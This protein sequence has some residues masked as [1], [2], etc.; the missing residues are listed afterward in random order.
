MLRNKTIYYLGLNDCEQLKQI[1][2]TDVAINRIKA[3]F[4]DCNIT[5]QEATGY[6]NNEKETTLIITI[7]GLQF[8]DQINNYAEQ[9]A[10]E[11][12][13]ICVLVENSMVDIEFV[14]NSAI[15]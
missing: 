12:N 4:A 9:L 14:H 1:I 15:V 2:S 8:T 3:L 7:I 6:Y 10:N 5:I 11:F 13:Q